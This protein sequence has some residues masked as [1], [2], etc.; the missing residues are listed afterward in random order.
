MLK[1]LQLLFVLLILSTFTHAQTWEKY[2][3]SGNGGLGDVVFVSK[4]RGFILGTNKVMMT[5]DTGKSWT[6]ILSSY[7]QF[8]RIMFADANVG[9]IIGYNDLV[10]KTT[11]GG[12][13]W[14]LKRTGNSDDD[15]ITLFAKDKDTLYVLGPDD[16]DN[17]KY[18]NYL[19]YSYNGGTTWGRRS[20]G[21][22]N[23][24]RS[25]YMWNKNKGLMSSLTGGVFQ[26][27]D[28]FVNYNVNW[29]ANN[30]IDTRV[31]KDSVVVVVGLNGK[32]LR[33]SNYGDNWKTI[34]SGTSENLMG[35][36]FANDSIGMACGEKGV[37]LYTNNGGL[38]WAKMTS[39]TSLTIWKVFVLNKYYAWAV[40]YSTNGDSVDI[41]KFGSEKYI[42]QNINNV[43]GTVTADVIKNCKKDSKET[44]PS[45]V[46]IKAVP[47]PYYTYSLL[48]GTYDLVIPDTGNY[49]ISAI[50]PSKY[51]GDK[52]QC[53]TLRSHS[54]Y[55]KSFENAANGKNFFFKAD[56][57]VKLEINIA[58]SRKRRCA[59]NN[60]TITYKNIG[61]KTIDSA[62]IQLFPSQY[63][64]IVKANKSY[65]KTNGVVTFKVGKLLP[66]EGGE[67]H[68]L[69][70]VFCNDPNIRG[71]TACMR[72]LI[73]P[74][75]FVENTVWDS[76]WVK[77]KIDCFKDSI[78]I[79]KLVND[80]KKPM[81]DSA[82]LNLF[83]DE[84]MVSSLKYKLASKDSIKFEMDPMGKLVFMETKLVKQHPYLEHLRVFKERCGDSAGF[85]SKQQ[86]IKHALQEYPSFEDEACVV[87][88]DSYDP[89]DISVSPEGLGSKHYIKNENKLR[90]TIRFQ[91]TGTDTAYNVTILDTLPASLNIASLEML[92]GSHAYTHK[93]LNE[94]NHYILKIDFKN[95]FLVD[96]FT[97]EKL[98]HGFISF[99]VK[100][101]DSLKKN[102]RIEN[103]V[104]I[105]FDFNEPVRTNT[106][107]NTLFDTTFIN[108]KKDAAK[109]CYGSFI[110]VPRDTVICNKYEYEVP[111]KIKG[112]NQP[113]WAVNDILTNLYR[114]NDTTALIKTVH[115]GKFIIT[116]EL[117][118][119]ENIWYDTTTVFFWKN[120]TI[121]VKDSLYCGAVNDNIYFSCFA[122]KYLWNGTDD[123]YNFRPTK[124]GKYWVT[125]TNLCKAITDTFRLSYLPYVKLD[126]GNDTLLCNQAKVMLKSDLKSG[127][128]F[129]NDNDTNRF[130]LVSKPGKYK[131][132]FENKCNLLSDSI[133]VTYK[134][135]P[136]LDLGKDSIYC[137]TVNHPISLDSIKNEFYIKW[138]DGSIV[139]SR[140]LIDKGKY[141]A[142]LSNYCGKATDTIQLGILNIPQVNLG[143]DSIYCQSFVKNITLA[144]GVPVYQINWWD[145]SSDMSKTL[146]IARKYYVEVFN[147][148]GKVSDTLSLS[149]AY[150]P[151][152][153]FGKDTVYCNNFNR[154]LD[155]TSIG[156]KYFWSTGDT[157]K[158]LQV[159]KPGTYWGRATSYCGFLT[160]TIQLDQKAVPLV[161][162]GRDTTLE[163]PFLTTLDAGNV[164]SSYL[165][166]TGGINQQIVIDNHGK[167]WVRVSN[168]CGMASDTLV[169][170]KPIVIPPIDPTLKVTPNP[171]FNGE[172]AISLFPDSYAL[173]LIDTYGHVVVERTTAQGV[174]KLNMSHYSQ[175]TYFLR[176]YRSNGAVDVVKLLKM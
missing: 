36:H 75:V 160:K 59:L 52:N 84:N 173:E 131:L 128:F 94:S 80:G 118:N 51:G 64:E 155:A 100:L 105:Y 9:Y 95:I 171:V 156:A 159:T 175:G 112:N 38:S 28:G 172:V 16:L 12:D 174:Y 63:N 88:R 44:G 24:I 125:A 26:T 127:K 68:V 110:K 15:L 86:V 48:N 6:R 81:G 150:L 27:K 141:Y 163:K 148:C 124:P 158:T 17:Y 161:N 71:L 96:S 79:I 67:I 56:S 117:K 106:A 65:K 47:G 8:S 120:P 73:T 18:G 123:S 147:R 107:F 169:I 119:C 93:F 102:T 99:D 3:K 164:G 97:N 76:S 90:Y 109:N 14:A 35:L 142:T 72:V 31:I 34:T 50:L 61:F 5:T 74:F 70:S 19:E 104:D 135:S 162:L 136:S 11:D 13:N 114:K 111:F 33:S 89:N 92:G 60:N 108:L 39:K 149:R 176:I 41:F 58:T 153:S 29:N 54:V 62:I 115:E 25:M 55:F 32:I 57:A 122:C 53:D 144:P 116:Y 4:S 151:D 43:R 146:I 165:W 69:D 154:L 85:F 83:L 42:E 66:G 21:S 23:T 121:K 170:N 145:G 101:S 22:T 133:E 138:W 20:T 45:G 103:F 91:N 126:L 129:W 2:G 166:S 167:Y 143:G 157:S 78:A 140:T 46:L 98:S 168:I 139:S 1:S 40:G 137:T 87:I 77:A 130:K 49:T 152:F 30:V 37:I 82:T 132:Q 7:S 10:L 134:R 113:T